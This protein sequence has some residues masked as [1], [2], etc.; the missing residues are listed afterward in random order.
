MPART[1]K[2]SALLSD[3]SHAAFPGKPFQQGQAREAAMAD[4]L[5]ELA[6]R[7]GVKFREPLHIDANGEF[8]LVAANE[9]NQ[10]APSDPCGYYGEGLAAL[11]AKHGS[12]TGSLAYG[13]HNHRAASDG[14]C[15]MNHFAVQA[16]LEEAARAS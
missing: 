13:Y 12:R 4:G 1:A 15:K 10:N 6:A 7:Y 8:S 9:A 16:M 3:Y 11:I 2:P 5:R 14:W